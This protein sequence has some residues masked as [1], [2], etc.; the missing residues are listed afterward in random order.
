M[1]GRSGRG[2]GNGCS[3]GDAHT[4]NAK[5]A[6]ARRDEGGNRLIKLGCGRGGEAVRA[7]LRDD[8]PDRR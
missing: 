3:W 1:V 6:R 7:K 2:P 4:R 8:P 5:D